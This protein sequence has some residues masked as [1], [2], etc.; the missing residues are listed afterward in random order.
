MRGG[1]LNT[2]RFLLLI[3]TLAALFFASGCGSSGS[4]EVTVQTGSLS[5]ADFIAKA[6]AICKAARTEFLAK[7][8]IYA[9]AHKTEL[10]DP[11]KQEALFSEVLETLLGPNVEGQIEQI[12]KLGA[13]DEYAPEVAGF[14]NA[15][16]QRLD[17]AQE[18]PVGLTKTPYPFKEAEDVAR[19]AGMNGCAESFS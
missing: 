14:L 10:G 3:A 7:F 12:G 13:P 18:D 17:E 16:Q 6:D 5:K 11:K 2:G 4:D 1:A 9:K 8:T 15:L 19:R